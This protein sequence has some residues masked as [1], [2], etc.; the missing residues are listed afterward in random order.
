MQYRVDLKA[1]WHYGDGSI[2]SH[3][4]TNSIINAVSRKHALNKGLK[5][6]KNWP[7]YKDRANAG[8]AVSGIA[9]LVLS[10][11][12]KCTHKPPCGMRCFDL[13]LSTNQIR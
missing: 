2:G 3:S 9:E 10:E 4:C 6:V 7:C 8:Q 13:T 1:F 5:I 11:E 12:F